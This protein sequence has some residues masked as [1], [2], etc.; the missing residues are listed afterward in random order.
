MAIGYGFALGFLTAVAIFLLRKPRDRPQD[1]RE[2][3]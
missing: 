3:R 2:G 1:P